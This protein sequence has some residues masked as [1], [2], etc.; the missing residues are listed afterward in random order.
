MKKRHL[1]TIAA[2]VLLIPLVA[3]TAFVQVRWDRTYDVP[4]PALVASTDPAV[5]EKG[6][7][8]AFGP[9][10][11]AACHTAPDDHPKL[12]A[13]QETQLKG[14]YQWVLPVANI[15]AA[16][17]TS[18]PE[19]GIG[20]YDDGQIARM[21]R[22]NVRPNGLPS[23]SFME[24]N[25]LSD[26]DIVALLSY[27]RS[28]APVRNEVPS[29]NY[30]IAGKAVMTFVV[31]PITAEAPPAKSPAEAPTI[32]RGDYLVN[33]VANCAGC[34]SKRSMVDGSYTGPR[35]AGGGVMP[36]NDSTNLVTPNLTPHEKTGHIA[37]WTE[38]QFIARFRA[39][40]VIKE[41]HM[42]WLEFGRMSDTDLRA[43]YRYLRSVPPIENET[44]SLVQRN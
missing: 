31:R 20:R 37:K 24:F 34:H 5:I 1:A 30:N 41:S 21:L 9:A 28:T 10:H 18:D 12:E 39:G 27:L 14:G 22:H 8:L 44:G 32:E 2:G 13:G 33:N 7:Y 40:K 4:K 16:N 42:P 38:E 15:R 3:T 6:R 35:L 17:I 36:I 19:T 26:E 29:S 23:P 43:I 25:R 11:C